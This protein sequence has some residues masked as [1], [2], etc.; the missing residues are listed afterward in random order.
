MYLPG[1]NCPHVLPPLIR[2]WAKIYCTI[3]IQLSS[4]IQFINHFY[5]SD[6]LGLESK[7]LFIFDVT[8]YDNFKL[9]TN[10]NCLGINLFILFLKQYTFLE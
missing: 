3:V 1:V 9:N 10:F 7:Q 2:L 8:R 5:H 6:L 4:N